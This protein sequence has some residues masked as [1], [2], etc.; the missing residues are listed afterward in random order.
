MFE[1]LQT[2]GGKLKMDTKYTRKMSVY[3]EV[4]DLESYIKSC[5]EKIFVE[6]VHL[7]W[8]YTFNLV[9]IS[10]DEMQSFQKGWEQHMENKRNLEAAK[11][12]SWWN[13]LMGGGKS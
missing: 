1:Y 7:E 4:R 8:C 2:E 5:A 11:D 6:S 12:V 9:F 10:L 3:S 13:R